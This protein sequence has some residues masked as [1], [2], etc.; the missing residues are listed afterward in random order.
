MAREQTIHLG[1]E[2]GTG[3]PVA[4]PLRH[5]AVTGQTQQSGK[6]TTLEALIARSGGTA[7]TFV[8]K[9][10]EGSFA[11]ARRIQPYFRDRADW[12]FVTS[13]LDATLQEKNKFLRPWIIRICR[14][15]ESLADVQDAVQEALETAKGINAGVY[16]QLDAYLELIVPEIKRAELAET[17]DLQPGINVM[18]V[19]DFATPMQMLFIQSALDFVN[20][21]CRNTTVVIP[22]AWEFVPQSKSSPVKASAETLVRKG[23]GIGNHIWLDSQDM[24]GV[25][26]LMLRA[27]TVWLIGVQREA[28]EIKRNL[29][30]IPAGM[31]RPRPE[32]IASLERGVFYACFGKTTVKVYVQPAWMAE[33]TA[34]AIARGEISIDEIA[35][36]AA[37][38]RA[39]SPAAATSSPTMEDEVD[40]ATARALTEENER[41][42][43]ELAAAEKRGFER[44]IEVFRLQASKFWH[45]NVLAL[46][47]AARS[48]AEQGEH[49]AEIAGSGSWSD[50]AGVGAPAAKEQSIELAGSAEKSSAPPAPGSGVPSEHSMRLLAVLVASHPQALTAELW[51]AFAAVAPSGGN[52]NA[53]LK[54]LRDAGFIETQSGKYA[55]TAAGIAASPTP[56]QNPKTTAE[57]YG[58]WRERMRDVVGPSAL[59]ALSVLVMIYPRRV[60]LEQ[61]GLLAKRATTGGN[62]NAA[63]KL[64]KDWGCIATSDGRYAASDLGVALC[65]TQPNKALKLGDEL[66]KARIDRLSGGARR[67]FDKFIEGVTKA[68]LADRVGVKASGGN[69]NAL[70]KE[71]LESGLVEQRGEKIFAKAE[72]LG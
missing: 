52:W 15:T 36:P 61:W 18:D 17:L 49:L 43:A 9:R 45:G 71:F 51:G 59:A 65:E 25:D 41:L 55:A 16:T 35:A 58:I 11:G 23:A 26:N 72:D 39:L 28:N 2:V 30:N 32:E 64:L 62:W 53:K 56:P 44:G 10:G 37:P 12:Q 69:W 42:K 21:N 4:V 68:E 14:A 70:I 5:M 20:A 47:D 34:R 50:I 29:A 24:A 7:L 38:A 22:E 19:S 54:Q 48:I 8:T 67:L 3:L 60:T 31:K 27:A 63:M 46:R 40:A 33:Q 66:Q 57:L 13:I 1:Y 6:T